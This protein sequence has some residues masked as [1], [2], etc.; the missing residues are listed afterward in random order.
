[1]DEMKFFGGDAV[2]RENVDDVAERAKENAGVE[3]KFVE[4][5]AQA[6]EIACIIGAQFDGSDGADGT[7]VADRGMI[8]NL[9]E[10]LLVDLGDGVNAFEDG[11]ALENFEAGDGGSGGDGISCVGMS[12]VKSAAAVVADEGAMNFFGAHGGSERKNAAGDSLR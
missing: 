7:D 11:L 4:L 5:G 9:G 1:M 12:V 10:T 2:G 3:E 6:R 8:S